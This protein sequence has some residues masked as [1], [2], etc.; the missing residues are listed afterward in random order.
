MHFIRRKHQYLIL[1]PW[2]DLPHKI[3]L[4]SEAVGDGFCL[5]RNIIEVEVFFC[6]SEDE[7]HTPHRSIRGRQFFPKQMFYRD[8]PK[9]SSRRR[10]HRK[11]IPPIYTNPLDIHRRP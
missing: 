5:F 4:S 9:I 2:L 7:L 3:N 6:P 10:K 8:T 1:F 11:N